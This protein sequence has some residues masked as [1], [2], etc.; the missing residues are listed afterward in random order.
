MLH[1]GVI[2]MGSLLIRHLEINMYTNLFVQYRYR[3]WIGTLGGGDIVIVIA[4]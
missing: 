4:W 3:V 2:F 1:D